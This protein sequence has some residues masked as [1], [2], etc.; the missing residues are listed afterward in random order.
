VHQTPIEA[1][2]L[3]LD[4][5]FVTLPSLR[6]FRLPRAAHDLQV[7]SEEQAAKA[8]HG[9]HGT[10]ELYDWM[11]VQVLGKSR[12]PSFEGSEGICQATPTRRRE[13]DNSTRKPP[14]P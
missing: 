14:E 3:R 13:L 8:D 7:E 5:F 2:H 4:F 1:G 9:R 11:R 10:H 6:P 12:K